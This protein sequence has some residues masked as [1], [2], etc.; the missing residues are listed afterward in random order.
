MSVIIFVDQVSVK[1]YRWY[2]YIYLMCF[3]VML[4]LLII[5]IYICS[6]R[7]STEQDC[8]SV[9]KFWYVMCIL[10]DLSVILL[11][12]RCFIYVYICTYVYICVCIIYMYVC[13]LD[14]IILYNR[15]DLVDDQ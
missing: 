2:V 11:A 15:T 8:W 12:F 1:T 6:W 14:I 13:L 9:R 10:L 4:L 3:C 5:Y 7:R